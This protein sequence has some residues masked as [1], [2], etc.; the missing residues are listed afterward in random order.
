[1]ACA[2]SRPF[3]P[4]K[5]IPVRWSNLYIER[6]FIADSRFIEW[7]FSPRKDWVISRAATCTTRRFAN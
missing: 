3:V 2:T 7:V 4:D 1:V 5:A 6:S